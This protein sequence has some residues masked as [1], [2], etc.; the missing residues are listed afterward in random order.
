M[1]ECWEVADSYD[2]V[3]EDHPFARREN[4]V[5]SAVTVAENLQHTG[6]DPVLW[7]TKFATINAAARRR[8]LHTAGG[9]VSCHAPGCS[10]QSAQRGWQRMPGGDGATDPVF[11]RLL[12]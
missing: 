12:Q 6:G 3:F 9:M 5:L 11:R 4:T 2:C 10:V 8:S 7:L 1:H